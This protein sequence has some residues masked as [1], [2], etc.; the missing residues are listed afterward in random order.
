MKKPR[1]QCEVCYM[2]PGEYWVTLED[3]S[4]ECM[5]SERCCRGC[6]PIVA[7][8]LVPAADWVAPVKPRPAKPDPLEGMTQARWDALTHDERERMRDNSQLS[9]Q[10]LGYENCR[11]EVVDKWNHKRRFWVGKSTGW[12]PIHLEIKTRRSTGGGGADREYKSVIVLP[13]RR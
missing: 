13:D 9:P 6:L 11:V 12:R 3:L 1:G 2:A 5:G 10:L 4:G 8:A 7:P